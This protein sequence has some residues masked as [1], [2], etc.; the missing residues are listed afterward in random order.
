LTSANRDIDEAGVFGWDMLNVRGWI[1]GNRTVPNPLS[2]RTPSGG[3]WSG[4]IFR[5]SFSA[6]QRLGRRFRTVDLG[7]MKKRC[8]PGVDGFIHLRSGVCPG[9]GPTVRDRVANP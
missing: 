5:Q 7:P 4:T 8:R 1:L 3:L 2:R 6:I 9:I